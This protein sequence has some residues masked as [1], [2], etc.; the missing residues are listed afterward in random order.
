MRL[1]TSPLFGNRSTDFLEKIKFPFFIISKMPPP[2]GIKINFLIF[3][4]Y[5]SKSSFARPAACG[6]KFQALQYSIEIFIAILLFC[7]I[8][9]TE[10]I[11]LLIM[12]LYQ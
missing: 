2:E 9:S 8:S 3:V 7:S 1:I 5:F 12:N 11:Q 10:R 4:P 6:R